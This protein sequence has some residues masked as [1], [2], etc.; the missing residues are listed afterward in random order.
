MLARIQGYFTGSATQVVDSNTTEVTLTLPAEP[1][2]DSIIQNKAPG[3]V[4]REELDGVPGAFLLSNVLSDDECDQF[5]AVAERLGF[6]NAQGTGDSEYIRAMPDM[7]HPADN[8][9]ATTEASQPVLQNLWERVRD[10]VPHDIPDMDRKWR[11]SES[12]N[13]RF[14]FLRYDDKQVFQPHFDGGFRRNT[15]E[16]S[17]YTFIIYLNDDFE[18]GETTFF[19]GNQ[20]GFHLKEPRQEVRVLPRRGSALVFRHTG[21]CSPLHEGSKLQT[22]GARKFVLRTDLMYTAVEEE[23]KEKKASST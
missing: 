12:M 19:P 22:Q 4:T 5:I 8:L 6:R 20:T 3:I 14:R 17:H 13:E 21:P 1:S 16:Q 9:S 10:V 7:R 15:N 11:V 2:L 18:G 23:E